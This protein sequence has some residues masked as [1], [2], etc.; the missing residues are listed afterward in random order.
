MA[1]RAAIDRTAR[2]KMSLRISSS[3]V[4]NRLEPDGVGPHSSCAM[5]LEQRQAERQVLDRQACGVE[6][7]NPIG[8]GSTPMGT[9]QDLAKLRDLLACQASRLDRPGE[10]A[11][12]ARLLP[13]VAEDLGRCDDVDVRLGLAGG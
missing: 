2:V 10:L 8:P 13:L 1:T 7:G 6:Q 11:S 4:G 3:N 5:R 9:G 12:V